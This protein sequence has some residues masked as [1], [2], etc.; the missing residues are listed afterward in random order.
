MQWIWQWSVELY[1]EANHNYDDND[2]VY[3]LYNKNVCY[4]AFYSGSHTI[5]QSNKNIIC[6]AGWACYRA[7]L[8]G[9]DTKDNNNNLY[10]TAMAA[11][12][13]TNI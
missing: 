10:C 8:Q 4:R 9:T 2:Y 7:Q 3:E 11:C 5:R 1:D 12:Y 6:S 13:I